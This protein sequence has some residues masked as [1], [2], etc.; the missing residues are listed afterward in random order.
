MNEE[1]FSK[2][3]EHLVQK[4]YGERDSELSVNEQIF[5]SVNIIRGSVPRSGFLG[6]FENENSNMITHAI[7]GLKLLHL[8]EALTILEKALM[9]II[10]NKPLPSKN[11]P[12]DIY[13]DTLTEDEYDELSDKLDLALQP[14]EEDFLEFDEQ[15]FNSLCDF[16]EENK[17]HRNG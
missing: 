8:P 11:E 9:V 10:G 4:K 12:L 14:F 2:Y 17:L 1:Q 5:Y 13:A 3:W 15:I 16:A 6:Y 7:E